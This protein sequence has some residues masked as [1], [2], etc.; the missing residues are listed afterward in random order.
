MI[1]PLGHTPKPF[2]VHWIRPEL[3]KLLPQYELISDAID[4]ETAIKD[5]GELYLPMPDKFNK[6]EYNCER[7]KAYLQR[8]VYYNVT[9]RTLLGLSGQVFMRDPVIELPPA[10]KALEDDATGTGV[11]LV[12]QA[13]ATEEM[14]LAFS[15]AGLFVDYPVAEGPTTKARMEQEDIRPTLYTYGPREIINWR[16]MERGSKDI[17][18]L[19]VLHETYT[20]NSDPFEEKYAEQY[21]VLRLDEFGEYVQEV[22]REPDPVQYDINKPGDKGRQHNWARYE[23]FKP[24]DFGGK[25]FK[26][27]P[28]TFVGTLNNDSNPDKPNFYDIASLNISHYR[29]SADIE[30]SSFLVGQP[31]VVASGLTQEWIKEVLKGRIEIG[32]RGGIPLPEGGDAKILQPVANDMTMALMERKER[33]MVSLG[34]KLV[35][36]PEVQRTAYETM[37]EASSDGS[38]LA[39]TTRNVQ[40][41]FEF[42]LKICCQFVGTTDTFKFELNNNFDITK[43]T[44]DEQAAVIKAWQDGALGFSEMRAILKRAGVATMEDKDVKAEALSAKEEAIDLQAKTAKAMAEAA[45]KERGNLNET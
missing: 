40:K 15:R 36:G 13:K 16:V 26:E 39:S 1:N 17:L 38:V 25:P 24:T 9:R 28:F 14:V 18:C 6:E 5:K 3:E 8:A 31:T 33:Q 41:A 4:G 20:F 19:V 44:P 23:K 11:P 37:V 45:P 43:L 10:L 32:S 29:N 27:I 2:N 34:A 35:E 22:W 7:Y 12:Q 30:E 42:A 21:R